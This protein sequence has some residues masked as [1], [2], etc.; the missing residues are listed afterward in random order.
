M[1][2]KATR[3]L[4][5][6]RIA[7]RKAKDATKHNSKPNNSIRSQL[8]N[9]AAQ[10]MANGIRP[11]GFAPQQY[12]NVNNERRIEQLRN[13]AHLKSSE[14]QN[15][16]AIIENMQKEIKD[17][18][19][20]LASAKK[21]KKKVKSQFDK[22]E[23]DKDM[24]EDILN[25]NIKLEMKNERLR[26]QTRMLERQNAL[27]DKDVHIGKLKKNKVDLEAN[28]QQ[29]Q[30][31]AIAKQKQIESNTIYNDINKLQ[32]EIDAVIA[33]N[34]A[35][36]EILKSDE[37]KKP[38]AE[39]VEKTKQLHLVKEKNRQN[40]ELYKIEL[41]NKHLQE[42]LAANPTVEELNAVAQQ[43][44]ARANTHRNNAMN[45]KFQQLAQQ[46]ALDLFNH[47]HDQYMNAKKDE[48]TEG[49]KL[50]ML[51]NQVKYT[52]DQLKKTDANKRYNAQIKR[53]ANIRIKNA[54]Q[55]LKL[56]NN[57]DLLK[58]KKENDIMNIMNESKHHEL[59]QDDKDLSKS[60]GA[61]KARNVALKRQQ[62]LNDDLYESKLK[63]SEE[64]ANN[65][66]HNTPEYQNMLKN[67][68]ETK[69]E[70]QKNLNEADMMKKTAA[71]ARQLEQSKLSFEVSRQL[72]NIGASDVEQVNFHLN[73]ANRT[74]QNMTAKN[75]IINALN[76]R[77]HTFRDRWLDFIR[78]PNYAGVPDVLNDDY[79]SAEVIQDIYNQFDR[80]LSTTPPRT[81]PA[82]TYKEDHGEDDIEND[83]YFL[84]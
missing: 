41:E 14:L 68:I 4:I 5:R 27:V 30:L 45:L 10:N 66:F 9:I 52:N 12:G 80:F 74:Y 29:K 77:I 63:S 53:T 39:Y 19:A 72:T 36:D 33:Q 11:F 20:D 44:A 43:F 76:Q 56:Q 3:R 78:L 81:P 62:R 82:I 57:Q 51:T 59:T 42:E 37:F 26:E 73:E 24:A 18:S 64:K 46:D 8:M 1:T 60:I 6:K 7:Q 40:Q 16:N 25:E 2:K 47:H 48:I 71:A 65:D 13:D 38:N 70:T 58:L 15:T 50:N 67:D 54:R 49:Y 83:N 31:E 17:L 79:T 69:V 32:N 22:A 55:A 23:H 28:L 35:Y 84:D 61:E 34:A 75:Q 21:E